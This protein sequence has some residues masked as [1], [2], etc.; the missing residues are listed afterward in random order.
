M[1]NDE[2]KKEQGNWKERIKNEF[3]REFKKGFEKEVEKEIEE[4]VEDE[5][6]E[7][8]KSAQGGSA[9][10]G[11][12]KKRK[13]PAARRVNYIFGLFF[14]LLFLWII[15]NINNWGWKFITEDWGQIIGVVKFS[16]YLSIVVYSAFILH[17]KKLFFYTGK[18]AMDVV[19]IYVSIRMYQIFP[20]DFEHL[21]GGWGWLNSVFPWILIIAVIGII[22]GII[23]RTGK[24]VVGKNIY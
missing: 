6:E 24:L 13:S 23:V 5:E 4:H 15:N 18:L 17:D 10:G 21:F 1:T 2:T 22:I 20:F 16:I 7:L 19:S 11:K 3:K 9:S 14:A 12:H 8:N